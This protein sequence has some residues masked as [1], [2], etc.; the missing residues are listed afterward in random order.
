M[1]FP[2]E[3]TFGPVGEYPIPSAWLRPGYFS[4]PVHTNTESY[5]VT[6]F[7][8]TVQECKKMNKSAKKHIDALGK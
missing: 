6:E 7:K 2:D 1:F 3:R 5:A 8:E 4:L